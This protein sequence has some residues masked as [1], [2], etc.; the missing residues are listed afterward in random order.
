MSRERFKPTRAGMINIWDYADEEFVFADGRLVL[1]GHNGS[2]K[3]KALEVLFPFVLD[4]YTDPRRLDPFSGQNRTMKSNLLY[5]GRDAEHGF[6]WM[7]FA[8]PAQPRPETVTLVIG[9]RAH[10]H[11]DGVTPSFFVTDKRLGTDFGLLAADG[12]PLTERRLKA[13]LGEGSH[14]STAADYRAA[15]DARLFGL[16]ERYV[17]LLDLLLALRRPLLAKDLDPEK[18]S[19]TL[20]AGL[21][22]LDE[23]LVDQ[24]AR[25]FANLAAVQR[26]FET[27]EAAHRA[28]ESF[29]TQYTSY[30]TAHARHRLSRVS[31][32]L[33]RAGAEAADIADHN[34]VLADATADSER[35]TAE[36]ETAE[37]LVRDL[38][39]R[40]KGLEQ[41]EALRSARALE[42]ELR[43][44]DDTG[45][46]LAQERRRLDR[47]AEEVDRLREDAAAVA[48]R[49]E[50]RRA[51]T[52]RLTADLADAAE[53]SGIASDGEGTDTLA[54]PGTARARAAARTEDVEAVRARLDDLEAADAECSRAEADAA[55]AADGLTRAE[56]EAA[57]AEEELAAARTQAAQ[58]L[59]RWAE[60]WTTGPGPLDPA[61]TEPLARALEEFGEP[62]APTPAEVFADLTEQARTE[63]VL[64]RGRLADERDRLSTDLE[65]VRSEHAAVAAERD[66]APPADRTR[67]APRPGRPGA[68]LWQLVRFA[69]GID[70]ARAAALEGALDGAG[71]LTAWVHPDPSATPS[72]LDGS[73]EADAYLVPGAPAAG[74]TLADVLLP[75]EQD[76]V[77]A[78]AVTA[79]LHSIALADTP[80]AP[81]TAHV[82]P[83]A[84]FGLGVLTG[85]HPKAAP[86]FIGATNRAARRRERLAA[87]R[88]RAEELDTAA[89]EADRR[90]AEADERIGAF[91]AARA[92]LPAVAPLARALK[93]VEHHATVVAARRADHDGARRRL[94]SATAER[95]SRR[96]RLHATAS[97]RAMPAV[98]DR[99]RAVAAAVDDFLAA[100]RDL[101]EARTETGRAEDDL[102][103]RR[104]AIA[105]LTAD[106]EQD[107]SAHRDRTAEHQDKLLE[108]QARQDA[109]GATAQE[110]LERLRTTGEELV[111]ARHD[112]ERLRAEAATARENAVRAEEGVNSGRRALTSSLRSVLEHCEGLAALTRPALLPLLLDTP[113]DRPWPTSWPTAEEAADRA[114]AHLA[115]GADPASAVRAV[116]PP[117]ATEILDALTGAVGNA[118]VSDS[119]LRSASTRMSEA[120]RVFTDALG[121]TADGHQVDHE[122]DGSGI[123]TVH[124]GDENGRNPLPA[125]ARVLADRVQE[126]DALLRHEERGVLEDELLSAVAQQIHDRVRTARDLVRSMDADTR[127]RPM[128]SG[129]QIGIRW[130]RSDRLTD[131]QRA[132]ADLVRRDGAGLGP[133]GLAELRAALRELIRDHR[134]AHPRATYKQVLSAVLDYRQ[135]YRFELRKAVPGQEEVRLTRGR[136]EEMS[137]GEKSAAIH[138]PLFAAANALYSS[139]RPDCPRLIALDE[140]FAGIDDRYK[141]ELMGLT[142]TFDLDVFMTGHDLWVHYDSVPMAAH[143]DMHHDKAAHT[144]SAMLMLWDGAQVVD[145]DAGFSG[146]EALASHLLG[147]TPSRHVP[148]ATEDTLPVT[149]GEQ[150]EQPA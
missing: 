24:A 128:T 79:I 58:A 61:H 48:R 138:L 140:A 145:A 1:R 53:R 21:S 8:R 76:R 97:E 23:E 39:A 143:Y 2:G 84:R 149:V 34:A 75:E 136:H 148:L 87:L 110:A 137:G 22:P 102:A 19:D 82:G 86:E 105:R 125:F 30:L 108:L 113:L 100:A 150:E 122:A 116:L 73:A 127:S 131:R 144:V 52:D 49:I 50:Q 47:Q 55:Q 147:F 6:V 92:D 62:G 101:H 98:P 81:G 32:S 59:D 51:D 9:L 64:H 65:Q 111:R 132:V 7:E 85:L 106:L 14:H 45:R 83:G 124:V 118:D 57:R 103:Q 93:A 56:A 80:P 78:E 133:A 63:A 89:A 5:G 41:D 70:P 31:T 13:V 25:D 107:E 42:L 43:H 71:L 90:L 54:D 129:T 20:T 29:T 11:R 134:A 38:E 67:T 33:D 114:A 37:R 12:R 44:S 119:A 146:N 115:E 28:V 36:A 4:G 35:L 91:T 109:V 15:V 117:G 135:W 130:T 94:D 26:R 46:A 77:P 72:L 18:V 10:Q 27:A 104:A 16:G 126:Q 99:V 112:L 60:R 95:D 139:A 142:V 88:A 141:P 17:Q 121:A 123:V 120:L 96:H 74:P 40:R 68:P 3:T 66:D 69:D